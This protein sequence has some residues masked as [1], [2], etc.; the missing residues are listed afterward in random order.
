MEPL[1]SRMVDEDPS[2]RPTMDEVVS[3]LQ[4]ILSEVSWFR[5]RARLVN[6]R[7]SPA[8]NFLKDVH[9]VSFRAIPFL[10]TCRPAIPS[11]KT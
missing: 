5:L 7:D 8:V 2:K 6:C 1:I 11:P 4:K 3:S 10:I 9:H